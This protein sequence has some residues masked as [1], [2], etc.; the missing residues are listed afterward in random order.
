MTKLIHLPQELHGHNT[1]TRLQCY[2]KIEKSK[3]N[4]V[5]KA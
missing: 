1:V 5:F 3:N 4:T 2:V